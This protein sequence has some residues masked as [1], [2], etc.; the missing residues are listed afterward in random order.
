MIPLPEF[1]SN[2]KR[3]WLEKTVFT[4]THEK[5]AVA[6]EELPPIIAPSLTGTAINTEMEKKSVY[7]KSHQ[8]AG[9][10]FT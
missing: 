1:V 7:L 4:R 8:P 2:L 3:R 6:I 5:F 10:T 9:L